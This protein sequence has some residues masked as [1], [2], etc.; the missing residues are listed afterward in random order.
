VAELADAVLAED[1]QTAAEQAAPE[2]PAPAEAQPAAVLELPVRESP[3]AN[4]V[5]ISVGRIVLVQI[6]DA[7]MPGIVSRVHNQHVLGVHV[8]VP[9]A[10]NPVVYYD[11]VRYD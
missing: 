1:G 7:V 10:R 3:D 9:R 2:A 6:G 5:P 8:C 11:P 4:P